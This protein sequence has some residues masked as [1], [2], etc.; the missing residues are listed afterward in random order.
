MG[1]S[2]AKVLGWM[3]AY[4]ECPSHRKF[5]QRAT[6]SHRRQR[7]RLA[8]SRLWFSVCRG[9]LI[10]GSQ[11]LNS[12]SLPSAPKGPRAARNE[13]STQGDGGKA[14][15]LSRLVSHLGNWVPECVREF[16]LW[17]A[18]LG[19]GWKYLVCLGST[20]LVLL[21]P[22]SKNH[23]SHLHSPEKNSLLES[24]DVN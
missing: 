22:L 16:P 24:S 21:R 14:K 23:P 4:W 5:S 10:T 2:E 18:A 13:C 7:A 9:Q 6:C 12:R 17:P 19:Q 8:H 15:A 11:K 20:G 3:P 1:P